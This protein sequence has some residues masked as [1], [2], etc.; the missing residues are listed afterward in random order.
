MTIQDLPTRRISF[1]VCRNPGRSVEGNQIVL[2]IYRDIKE[3][4]LQ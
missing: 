1:H 4:R 3:Q 2:F